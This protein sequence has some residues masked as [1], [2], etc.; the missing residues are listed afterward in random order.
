MFLFMVLSL[1]AAG[2]LKMNPKPARILALFP[3]SCKTDGT[4]AFVS[5]GCPNADHP[6]RLNANSGLYFSALRYTGISALAVLVTLIAIFFT[7]NFFK[8][9]FVER[10]GVDDGNRQR[11][12]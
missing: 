2:I 3:A 1:L 8:A 12:A 10:F 6:E 7:L 4:D 9:R 11:K 5:P